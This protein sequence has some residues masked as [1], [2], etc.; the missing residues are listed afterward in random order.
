MIKK[1]GMEGLGG[2]PYRYGGSGFVP[3]PPSDGE[4]A[5]TAFVVFGLIVILIIIFS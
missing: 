1:S 2:S 3:M 5:V 4:R